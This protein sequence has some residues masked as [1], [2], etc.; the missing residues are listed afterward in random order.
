MG[1]AQPKA[2][3]PVISRE[4]ILAAY[5]AFSEAKGEKIPDP[6]MQMG[7]DAIEELIELRVP[8]FDIWCLRNSYRYAKLRETERR[9]ARHSVRQ[10]IAA[11]SLGKIEID[12]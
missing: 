9:L 4:K 11:F 12:A 7:A 10:F 2:N 6:A 3:E 5:H 8:A 1:R